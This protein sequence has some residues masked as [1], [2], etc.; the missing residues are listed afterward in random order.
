MDPSCTIGFYCGSLE[1]FHKLRQQAEKVRT[2]TDN[3]TAQ[4][5]SLNFIAWSAGTGATTAA[6]GVSILFLL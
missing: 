6:R 1:E 4:H 2:S 5:L 3:C